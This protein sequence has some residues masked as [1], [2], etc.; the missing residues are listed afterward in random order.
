M[1][2]ASVEESTSLLTNADGP[3][4]SRW[5]VTRNPFKTC[6]YELT[7]S[8]SWE[9]RLAR[10]R[11]GRRKCLP[12]V[13]VLTPGL[14]QLERGEPIDRWRRK[15]RIYPRS[16]AHEPI[17]RREGGG[18]DSSSQPG[19]PVRGRAVARTLSS[20]RPHGEEGRTSPGAA[21]PHRA[22]GEFVGVSCPKQEPIG[23]NSEYQPSTDKGRN[24]RF[25]SKPWSRKPSWWASQAENAGSIP[26]AR[27]QE[28]S[29]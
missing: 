20:R 7:T 1:S 15:S 8:S 19:I 13:G 22:T 5:R 24:L 3:S 21:V 18:G 28:T 14:R 11:V 9:R 23:T 10:Y 12:V 17:G 29:W 16:R 27:S 4:A 2:E 6:G 25:P 26:V